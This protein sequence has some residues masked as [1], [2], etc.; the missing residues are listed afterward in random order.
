MTDIVSTEPWARP[1]G[2]KPDDLRQISLEPAVA[3]Y[4]EG[5][6]L[7]KFGD[8]HVLCAA[9]IDERV[10]PFLRNSGKGWVTAE[11]GMLPRSTHTRTDREAAKGK[12][13]GRTQEIQRLIGRALRAA[14]DLAA[15][16]ERQIKIDCDV[17]QADGGTRTASITGAYVA[18]ELACRKLVT[19]GLLAAS[20]VVTEVAAVSCGIYQGVPVLD[21]DYAEDSNA[22]ADANFVLT[23]AGGIIE[24]QGTAE[25]EPFSEDE[26]LGLL[27]LAK[28]GIGQLVLHQ[29]KALGKA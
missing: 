20:P 22:G 6:C 15:L 14:T 2:R 26:F 17:L 24:I 7:A 3:K 28:L 27:S 23:G 18:L 16:G 5:S 13:S 10:P 1:S 29:R 8:T 9:S 25:Q 11:Y 12:Q 21:L 4:A 19:D